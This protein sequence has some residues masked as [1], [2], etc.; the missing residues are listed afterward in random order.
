MTRH[1]KGKY[2]CAIGG[3]PVG[4]IKKNFLTVLLG[5]RL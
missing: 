5:D 4:M 3:G 2:L 1:E